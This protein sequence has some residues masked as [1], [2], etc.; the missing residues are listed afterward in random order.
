MSVGKVRMLDGL[1]YT[2][3]FLTMALRRLLPLGMVVLQLKL[4]L[5]LLCL[6]QETQVRLYGLGRTKLEEIWEVV[7]DEVDGVVDE[8]LLPI[9]KYFYFP[10]YGRIIIKDV[11]TQQD[12][13]SK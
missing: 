5:G 13:V 10:S 2:Q 1:V 11:L 6:R 3:C 12:M 8:V 7:A 4:E 9:L